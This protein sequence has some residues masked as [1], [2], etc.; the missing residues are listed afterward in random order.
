MAPPPRSRAQRV[1]D[2]LKRLDRDVDAWIATAD[3]QSGTPHLVPLSF[4]WDGE[5]LLVAT[6]PDSRTGR[7]LRATGRARIGLGATRDVVV[8]DGSAR[9]LACADIPKNMADEFVAKTGFD[10]R[11]DPEGYC[12]F[13][14]RPRV[15]RAWRNAGELAG[16]DVMR[17]GEWITRPD[18]PSQGWPEPGAPSYPLWPVGWVRSPLMVRDVGPRRDGD[19]SAPLARVVF[20][21]ALCEAT[22]DLRVGEQVLLLTFLHQAHRDVLAVRPL[23]DPSRRLR[24]VFS[25][26]SPDRPNPI[27]LHQVTIASI[28][29]NCIVVRVLE[30]I[31]GTPVLDVK[32]LRHPDDPPATESPYPCGAK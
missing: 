25:T 13:R 7:N 19:E 30:A 26:R 10:P 14:I 24:G 18:G 8:I 29:D 5:S 15:A 28:E 2:T 9:A 12:F 22:A 20:N 4:L 27:G 23:R 17:D 31:D 6:R 32:P 1:R 3:E 21:P 11:Q 16:R